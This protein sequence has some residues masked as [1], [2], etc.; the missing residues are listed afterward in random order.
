MTSCQLCLLSLQAC[1]LKKKAGLPN[2][3]SLTSSSSFL[4]PLFLPQQATLCGWPYS[5][6]MSP[7]CD[8]LF[9]YCTPA[10]P[11]LLTCHYFPRMKSSCVL[12]RKIQAFAYPLPVG[13]AFM[14]NTYRLRRHRL[15]LL[16]A[17]FVHTGQGLGHFGPDGEGD[18]GK[19]EGR[20]ASVS[21]LYIY[22]YMSTLCVNILLREEESVLLLAAS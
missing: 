20:K 18:R 5:R 12:Q 7:V 15:Y 8:R 14:K 13:M 4:L 21:C 9:L 22:V 2:L 11:P 1:G 3:P 17:A 10:S 16:P 6:C 19:K